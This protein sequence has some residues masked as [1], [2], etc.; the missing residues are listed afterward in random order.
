MTSSFA[1]E[2]GKKYSIVPF[3]GKKGEEGNYTLT[4]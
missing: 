4:L 1:A 3:T 2:T